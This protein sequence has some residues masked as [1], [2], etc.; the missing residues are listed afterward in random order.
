MASAQA[1]LPWD[2]GCHFSGERFCERPGSGLAA[3][4]HAKMFNFLPAQKGEI[5]QE[6]DG[7]AIVDVDE[8]LIEA[9]GL[10]LAG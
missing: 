4:F 7:V 10:V 5:F 9:I 1:E 3:I 2:K 6:S 8:K